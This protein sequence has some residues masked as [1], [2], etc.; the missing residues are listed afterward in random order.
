MLSPQEK[1]CC[2][3]QEETEHMGSTNGDSRLD[4]SPF[5]SHSKLSIAW[6]ISEESHVSVR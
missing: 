5:P 6:N 4:Y 2:T 3:Q 1:F